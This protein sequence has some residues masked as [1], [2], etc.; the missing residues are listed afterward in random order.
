MS[1]KTI[2]GIYQSYINDMYNSSVWQYLSSKYDCKHGSRSYHDMSQ[3][4]KA[5]FFLLGAVFG[6]ECID[7]MVYDIMVIK[8]TLYV[9]DIH[10]RH[11][12]ER[13]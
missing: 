5:E 3:E 6:S 12:Y 9:L 7:S 1:D 4:D 2:S 13:A 8:D 11:E 10:D